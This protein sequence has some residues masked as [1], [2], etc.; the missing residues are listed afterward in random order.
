MQPYLSAGGAQYMSP[1]SHPYTSLPPPLNSLLI[2]YST[3][4]YFRYFD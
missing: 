3:V 1:A 4:F 2:L